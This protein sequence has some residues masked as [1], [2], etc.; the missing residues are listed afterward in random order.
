MPDTN[1][2]N[3][4]ALPSYLAWEG[5]ADLLRSAC[6]NNVRWSYSQL[7]TWSHEGHTDLFDQVVALPKNNQQRLL[8]APQAFHVLQSTSQ[9]GEVEVE[10][11]RRFIETE[12]FLCRQDGV[13]PADSWSAL[14]D[15]YL[16]P[17]NPAGAGTDKAWSIDHAYKAKPVGAMIVDACSPYAKTRYP[18]EVGAPA[19]HT[20][21]EVEAITQRVQE[22]LDQILAVSET[23]RLTV[24]SSTQ[25][26]TVI[27]AP[28]APHVTASMST[29]VMIGRVGM[30]NLHS[31]RWNTCKISNQ[32]VHEAIHS[33]IYKL[34]LFDSL[35]TD[36]EAALSLKAVSPWSGR[37]LG[38]HSFVHACFVWFGLWCFWN[39]SGNS[40][41]KALKLKSKAHKGFLKGVPLSG[42]SQEAFDCIMPDVRDAIGQMHAYIIARNSN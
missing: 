5:S 2:A 32:I 31:N 12:K 1:R 41:E 21:D 25:V 17:V 16:P 36:Q 23:A 38:L 19:L 40:D 3:I 28:A 29:R 35:Y 37:T 7:R 33:M 14:G 15:Y 34:E 13:Y 22:S 27:K 4:A 24:D 26:M 10:T 9:P 6:A 20:P 30:V 42:I 18:V 39:K 8:L 11:F